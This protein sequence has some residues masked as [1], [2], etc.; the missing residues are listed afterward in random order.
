M[1]IIATRANSTPKP[2]HRT[3]GLTE[4]IIPAFAELNVFCSISYSIYLLTVNKKYIWLTFRNSFVNILAMLK[5]RLQ[6]VGRKNDP[7]FRVVVTDSKRGPKSGDNVELLGSYNPHVNK[8]QING[9]RVK[10]WIS[11]GAQVS[12]TV[13]NLLVSEKI[14]EGK[15]VNVLPK[16]SPIVKEPTEE[17]KK[18]EEEKKEEASTEESQKEEEVKTEASVEE[19]KA[20][21]AKEEIKEEEKPAEPEATKGEEEKKPE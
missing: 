20:E 16:K 5:I 17:E 19:P 3:F 15:K 9:E 10:H 4:S 14:I 7:S 18:A 8:V 2:I 6:R 21:D 11:V 12:D 1:L 13:H